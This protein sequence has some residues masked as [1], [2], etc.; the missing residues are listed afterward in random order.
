MLACEHFTK[1][2]VDHWLE[3]ERRNYPI[4]IYGNQMS[5]KALGMEMMSIIYI[6]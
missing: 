6:L 3:F 1:K 2:L 4:N 5:D